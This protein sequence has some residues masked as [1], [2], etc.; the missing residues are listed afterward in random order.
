MQRG[1]TIRGIVERGIIERSTTDR[2]TIERV[3]ITKKI[4]IE[5]DTKQGCQQ[6]IIDRNVTEKSILKSGF[7]TSPQ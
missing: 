1:I 3:G 6:Y 7:Q 4:I 2:D 5:R